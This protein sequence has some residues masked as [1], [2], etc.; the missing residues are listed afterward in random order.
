MKR[1]RGLD[2]VRAFGAIGII[3]FHFYC[4]VEGSKL[5]FLTHANGEWGGSLNYLF[6][7][8]SGFLLYSKNGNCG[9]FNLLEFYYKR[10]KAMIPAYLV[11]FAYAFIMNVS[12]YG[13]FFYLDIPNWRILLTLFGMDGYFSWIGT[14]YFITGEWFLGA[15]LMA[16]GV[17]PLLQAWMKKSRW[18]LLAGL[19]GA[20][21]VVLRVDFFG[22]PSA[23]NPITCI[24]CFYLGM[25]LAFHSNLLDHIVVVLGSFLGTFILLIIPLP[26]S[27]VTKNILVGLSLFISLN[28]I[29]EALCKNEGVYR[30][31][32]L[33]SSLSYYT[34]LLHHQIIYKV[35]EGFNS[36]GT[37]Y[38]LGVLQIIILATLL[39]SYVLSIVM[40]SL[41]ESRFYRRLETAIAKWF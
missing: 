27:A 3:A 13:E 18:L 37:F 15:I 40:K 31:V 39:F 23:V 8:L 36:V 17:Y 21:F 38:S 2:F 7:I 11:V 25:L 22:I 19:I 14:T 9:R 4:H 1:R 29:G 34:F 24:L 35:L 33:I 30:S 16:Y 26:G 20:Y 10:W 41:F 5:L 32:F 28:K 6:F 12:E